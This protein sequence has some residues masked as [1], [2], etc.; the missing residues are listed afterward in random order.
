MKALARCVLF[1]ALILFG[2]SAF[3]FEDGFEAQASDC[4]QGITAVD[5]RNDTQGAVLVKPGGMVC[6][7]GSVAAFDCQIDALGICKRETPPVS[8]PVTP[9]PT[10]NGIPACIHPGIAGNPKVQPA[11]FVGHVKS[12]QDLMVTTTDYPTV[13]G[14][15]ARPIGSFSLRTSTNRASDLPMAGRYITTRIV[16][17]PAL[18]KVLTWE[19]MQV[20]PAVGYRISARHADSI[21]VSISPC[22]GDMRPPEP[23]GA[24]PWLKRCRYQG[25]A[26]SL[27]YG[28]GTGASLCKLEPGQTYYLTFAIVDTAQTPISTSTTTCATVGPSATSGGRCEAQFTH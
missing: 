25:P 27:S 3:P 4:K 13:A 26:A 14:S 19:T 22:A 6:I 20:Q 28:T 18:F 8:P 21:F 17:P 2:T 5:A 24:D 15:G 7:D 16:I 23:F 1:A 10:V 9:P 12:W 11:G